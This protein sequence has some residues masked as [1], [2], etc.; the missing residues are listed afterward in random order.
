MRSLL[1]FLA[2]SLFVLLLPFLG[3]A[4]YA[5]G[6]RDEQWLMKMAFLGLSPLCVCM[7]GALIS[8]FVFKR[9]LG[10]LLEFVIV[11]VGYVGIALLLRSGM[12]T[13]ER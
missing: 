12:V 2:V 9:R 8:N 10:W 1:N 3:I 7:W 6:S 13:F 5:F 4:A 11:L